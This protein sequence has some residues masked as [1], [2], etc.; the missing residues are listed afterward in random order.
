M[1]HSGV[2]SGAVLI[3]AVSWL[4]GPWFDLPVCELATLNCP[5]WECVCAWAPMMDLVP[6]IHC[7]LRAQY[8]LGVGLDTHYQKKGTKLYCSLLLGC[9]LQSYNFSTHRVYFFYN[10]FYLEMCIQYTFTL[11]S[12][13]GT[14]KY[15]KSF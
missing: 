4:Q 9:Y 15:L 2:Y 8:I 11:N 12:N 13:Y 3:V 14:I 6:R 10:L 1:T 5:R 7:S